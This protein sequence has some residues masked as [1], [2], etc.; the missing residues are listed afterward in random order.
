ML[1]AAFTVTSK[2]LAPEDSE[3]Y[4][5]GAK[6]R[7]P[8][9]MLSAT[10][11][12]FDIKKD[13]ALQT[14]PATGFLLA[15]SGER[16]EVKGFELGLIGK[17][18]SAWTLSA[19]YTYLDAQI[20]ESFSNCAV[21]TATTGTPSGVV[22][23]VGVTAPSPV[24][25]TVAVGQQVVFVPKHSASLFT[26]YDLGGWIDGLSV[27]GDV[28]YQSRQFLGYMPAA[29]FADRTDLTALIAEAPENLTFDAYV[30]YK[31]GPYRF[32]I[33]GYNLADRL[34]YTQVFGTRATPSPG[35]TIIFSVG[36]T[37]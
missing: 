6:F 18:T 30:S 3:I 19:G 24:V 13:N 2:D 11:S 5:A 22:C 23:P 29:A 21:P 8:G 15:Q 14:D 20:K 7:V 31:T 33:N 34:N 16:Q 10:G 37:F 26:T 36:A 4:E 1:A 28:T 27:G 32:A 17:L 12:L 25:N 35:R 9:T